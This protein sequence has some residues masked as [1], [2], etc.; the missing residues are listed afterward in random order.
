MLLQFKVNNFRSIKDTETFSMLTATQDSGSTFKIRDYEILNSAVFYGA[1]ASGKSNFLKAMSFMKSMV[2]NQH[3]ITQSTDLIPHQPFKLNSETENASST[4]EMVFFIGEI[5]YRYGF[6]TDNTTV[7]SEWLFA[8]EKG[9]ESK[10]FFRELEEEVF[11]VNENKFKEGVKLKTIPNKLFLWK[12]DEEGGEISSSI[13]KWFRDFNFIDGIQHQNFIEYTL[14]QMENKDF[15]DAIVSLVKVA[16]I[17]IE[18]AEKDKK[19]YPEEIM[20]ILPFND[21]FKEK[22]SKQGMPKINTFHKKFNEKNEEI[23]EVVFELD[24]EESIGTQKFFKLSAPILNTLKEGKVLIVDELDASLHPVLTKHLIALFN[25]S[26]INTKNAQ[27]IFATHDTN[28]L[29][30]CDFRRDQIWFSEK[31]KYGSTRITSLSDIK[32]VRPTDNFEKNYIHG[33]YGAIP[34]IGKFEF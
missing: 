23:G 20:K 7:Y 34:Y 30:S 10:L 5:K 2:L 16:D 32:G 19:D 6:E 12:C 8:D 28:L 33:K 1:N 18:N 27:L 26:N 22:L 4:F 21:D 3:K 11:Y 29:N 24:I 25:D 9:K 17:G 14:K 31:D 15:K 13:L